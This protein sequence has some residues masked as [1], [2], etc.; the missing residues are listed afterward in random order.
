MQSANP[1]RP[2][3]YKI[4]I[5][6]LNGTAAAMNF[7]DAI[8]YLAATKGRS[9][10]DKQHLIETSVGE[11]CELTGLT[12]QS[13]AK[14]RTE[15]AG[16]GELFEA[17][18][19]V[20]P[21]TGGAGFELILPD[22]VGLQKGIVWKPAGYVRHGWL[23]V[24]NTGPRLAH[25]PRRVLNIF[26]Q[27]PRRWVYPI[28]IQEL[29]ARAR[30]PRH[31]HPPEIAEIQRALALLES[32]DLL[33][34]VE[35]GYLIHWRAFDQPARHPDLAP[36]LP[37]LDHLPALVAAQARD[38]HRAQMA[39]ELL[40]LGRYDPYCHFEAIFRD[41]NYLRPAD[42]PLLKRKAHRHRRR[43]PAPD[44]WAYTWRRFH[45]D[46]KKRTENLSSETL[47]LDLEPTG[48][49]EGVLSFPFSSDPAELCWARMVA[50]VECPEYIASYAAAHPDDYE[51]V[52]T[53]LSGEEQVCTR[54]AW[55][56]SQARC[57]VHH[58]VNR[59]PAGHPFHLLAV[60]KEPLP[61]VRVKARLEGEARRREFAKGN[62]IL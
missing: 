28:S 17:A 6:H 12:R 24:L 5:R 19:F 31:K 10:P 62:R 20:F 8:Y 1:L 57:S 54:V 23:K 14:L 16:R 32:L 13:L 59:Q 29:Q 36:S 37:D 26:F 35:E 42:L 18:G 30:K 43:P 11:L 40:K 27:L 2:D 22:Y 50:W 45:A 46:L 47:R 7:W 44:K 4:P 34:T 60:A 15:A 61:R 53:L 25:I 49:A 48:R 38:P 3:S 41:L 52:L 39:M 56:D 51:I 58:L 21:E 9:L 55:P 33:E